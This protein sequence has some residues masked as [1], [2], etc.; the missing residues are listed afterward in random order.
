MV[1]PHHISRGGTTGH[2]SQA[3]QAWSGSKMGPGAALLRSRAPAT[4]RWL[5]EP[6]PSRRELAFRRSPKVPGVGLPG[7][8]A[9]IP[10]MV[11]MHLRA[12]AAGPC[13][14]NE[15]SITVR[16]GC[17][18]LTL[19]SPGAPPA[20][21]SSRPGT[22]PVAGRGPWAN[23]G[24]THG[25]TART[26]RGNPLPQE[27]VAHVSRVR[28]TRTVEVHCPSACVARN[29]GDWS[30]HEVRAARA[31]L[32]RAHRPGATVRTAGLRFAWHVHRWARGSLSRR[33]SSA[34]Q[35]S[36]PCIPAPGTLFP[37]VAIRA[38]AADVL[39]TPGAGSARPPIGIADSRQSRGHP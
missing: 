21:L 2:G 33:S 28:N 34:P 38:G 26:G 24:L 30:H 3:S 20:G 10:C 29:R 7:P 6:A 23:P 37:R 22:R 14:R 13:G 18:E 19:P 27:V 9:Q 1:N 15:R 8:A 32:S 39:L 31:T 17:G 5:W 16:P 12:R 35:H 25:Q 4:A 11:V 36:P